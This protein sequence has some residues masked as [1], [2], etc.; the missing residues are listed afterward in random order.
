MGVFGVRIHQ[1]KD[2]RNGADSAGSN[3]FGFLGYISQNGKLQPM[4]HYQTGWTNA[5][6]L[7]PINQSAAKY[8][9]NQTNPN[10]SSVLSVYD[11]VDDNGYYNFGDWIEAA[12]RQAGW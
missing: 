6:N 10:L 9:A 1:L 5:P 12:A 2:P 3:P 7:S 8:L 4:I 11:W